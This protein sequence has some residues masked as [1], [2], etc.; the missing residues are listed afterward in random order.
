M[1]WPAS[2]EELNELLAP[3]LMVGI[4]VFAFGSIAAVGWLN[5]KLEWLRTLG[6][7][8]NYLPE[9]SALPYNLFAWICTGQHRQ[10]ADR[11]TTRAVYLSRLLS[12]LLIGSGTLLVTLGS[13][14]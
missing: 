13:R 8:A 7:S 10:L 12:V 1:S 14:H 5:G 2:A 9:R 11:A 3:P 6:T 4:L